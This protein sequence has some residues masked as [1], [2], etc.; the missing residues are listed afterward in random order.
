MYLAMAFSVCC[1]VCRAIG[2]I[3]SDLM[4]LK[5]VP[6]VSIRAKQPS[7]RSAWPSTCS[8]KHFA[9]RRKNACHVLSPTNWAASMNVS[10]FPI[11][12]PTATKG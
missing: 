8:R 5:K 1:R 6:S 2:Q 4:D 10:S 11:E 3:S 9:R 7:R 12:P